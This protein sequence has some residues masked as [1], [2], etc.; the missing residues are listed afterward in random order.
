MP[1]LPGSLRAR[2]VGAIVSAAR[3]LSQECSLDDEIRRLSSLLPEG[4][5]PF[6]QTHRDC[7]VYLRPDASAATTGAARVFP[8]LPESG[9]G[10]QLAIVD[11]ETVWL[12]AITC[13][14]PLVETI[15]RDQAPA[16][17]QGIAGCSLD[18]EDGRLLDESYIRRIDKF[19][20]ELIWM[21]KTLR[22]GRAQISLD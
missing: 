3:L 21:A 9:E 1:A 14:H 7:R 10:K 16:E 19:L 5:K 2:V 4:L 18:A 6:G 15:R 12:F 20:K 22:Q 17:F 8:S 11:F 13:A